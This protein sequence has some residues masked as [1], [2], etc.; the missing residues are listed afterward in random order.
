MA[1]SPD[2]VLVDTNVLVYSLFA[3][4]EHHAAANRL[5]DKAQDGEL[6]LCLAPQVL[7]ELYAVI[8]DSRRVTSPYEPEEAIETIELFLAM[9]GVVLLP[10]PHDLVLRWIEL[11]RQHPVRR[12][13]VFDLQLIALMLANDV[14][15]VY[16]FNVTDFSRFTQIST[17]TP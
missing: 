6:T 5:L 17:L 7:A 13:E 2:R 14:Q 10:V 15:S 1:T 8:T 12:G 11:L 3:D 16:T 4:S 9:P